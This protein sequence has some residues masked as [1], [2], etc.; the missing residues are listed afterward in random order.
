MKSKTIYRPN[1]LSQELCNII[2]S[3]EN[4]KP[5]KLVNENNLSK[6]KRNALTGLTNNPNIVIQKAGKVNTFVILDKEFCFETLV[7]RQGNVMPKI[8]KCQEILEEI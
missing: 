1:N 3:I 4:T 8:N 7:R 6:K 2:T 5:I